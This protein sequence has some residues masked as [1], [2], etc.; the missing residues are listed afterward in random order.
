MKRSHIW[1]LNDGAEKPYTTLPGLPICETWRYE[2]DLGE[3]DLLIS[4]TE[5]QK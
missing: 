5:V 4:L 2:K 1:G 3:L